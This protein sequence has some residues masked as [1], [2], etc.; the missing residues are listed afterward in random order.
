MVHR[1]TLTFLCLIAF[2][3]AAFADQLDNSPTIDEIIDDRYAACTAENASQVWE[4]TLHGFSKNSSLLSEGVP[5][6]MDILGK[7]ISS[8]RDEKGGWDIDVYVINRAI[9]FEGVKIVTQDYMDQGFD[10]DLETAE[11]KDGTVI[12][13]M[14]VDGKQLQLMFGIRI[15]STREQVEDAL[16]LPCWPVAHSGRL[17]VRQLSSYEYL[18]SDPNSSAEYSVAFEFDDADTVKSVVWERQPWH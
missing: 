16:E 1:Q 10:V 14:V 15:G 11:F 17:A 5:K 3:E 7:P 4:F 8:E 2:G 18:T 12:H 6:A 13:K 9:S